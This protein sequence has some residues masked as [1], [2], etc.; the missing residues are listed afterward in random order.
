MRT[1]LLNGMMREPKQYEGEQMKGHKVLW[2][3]CLAVRHGIR[4]RRV[5]RRRQQQW[6]WR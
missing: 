5:R 1:R 6:W 3:V 2:V 4:G